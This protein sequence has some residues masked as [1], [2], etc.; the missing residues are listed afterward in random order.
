MACY[1]VVGYCIARTD[2]EILIMTYFSYMF[3]LSIFKKLNK[4]KKE[5]KLKYTYNIKAFKNK[6]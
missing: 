2:Q 6:K 1:Y 4:N 3:M 5:I